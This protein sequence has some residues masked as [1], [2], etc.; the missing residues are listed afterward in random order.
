MG[1]PP[2]DDTRLCPCCGGTGLKRVDIPASCEETAMHVLA[3]IRV[4]GSPPPGGLE[5]SMVYYARRL[6]DRAD[7]M[8][9]A[10]HRIH[11][12]TVPLGN[13]SGWKTVADI[14]EEALRN[15]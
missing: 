13:D 8:E 2:V 15:G 5:V 6:R 1:E 4:G 14:A 9:K 11:E 12:L 7:K 3:I 10:L